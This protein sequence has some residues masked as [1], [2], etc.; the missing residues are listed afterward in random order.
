MHKQFGHPS[1]A[2]LIRLVENSKFKNPDVL[3]NIKE[4]SNK[5]IICMKRRNSKLKPVVCIPLATSFNEFVAVDLKFWEKYCFIVF[6]DIATRYCAAQ[7]ICDK[8][9]STI[10]SAFFNKWISIFGAPRKL[11]SDN[12]REF[13]NCELRSLAET[14][15]FLLYTTAAESPWSNGIVERLNGILGQSVGKIK[16]D[17]GCNVHI[18]LA[19]AVAARNA[20][21]NNGG[22]S[23]NTLVF[24]FNPAVPNVFNSGPSWQGELT[25][26]DIVRYNLQALHKA[27]QEYT[28]ASNNEKIR[29]ALKYKTRETTADEVSEGDLV[30]YKRQKDDLL[31]GPGTVA[32][33]CGKTVIVKHGGDSFRVHAVSIMKAPEK[34]MD[35]NDVVE[36][37]REASPEKVDST[38]TSHTHDSGS[39]KGQK[40]SRPDDTIDLPYSKIARSENMGTGEEARCIE[41]LRAGKEAK[42]DKDITDNEDGNNSIIKEADLAGDIIKNTKLDNSITCDPVQDALVDERVENKKTIPKTWKPKMRFHG[43]SK[44][45]GDYVSGEIVSRAGKVSGRNRSQYNVMLDQADENAGPLR[46]FDMNSL[47][48]LSILE[49]EACVLIMYSNDEVQQAKMK[50]IQAWEDNKVIKRVEDTG[51]ETISLRWVLTKKDDEVGGSVIKARLVARGYEEDKS[52]LR[53]DSPT[54]SKEGLRILVSIAS[55]F[56]WKC[57][58]IDVRAAYLQG[59]EINRELY[60]KPPKEF[61]VEGEVWRLLKTIYGL[62]DAARAWFLKVNSVLTNLGMLSSEL[63]NESLYYWAPQGKLQGLLA[64]HVDDF[65]YAG[66]DKFKFLVMNKFKTEFQIGSMAEKSFTY[67]GLR[68]CTFE[69][70]ITLDQVPY[71]ESLEYIPVDRA[72]I[73]MK[74][75]PLTSK[76]WTL[77]RAKVGQLNWLATHTRPDLAYEVSILGTYMANPKHRDIDRINKLINIAKKDPIQLYFPRLHKNGKWNMVCY[78]DAATPPKGAERYGQSDLD[79]QRSQGAHIIFLEDNDGK[80]TPIDWKSKKI[81]RVVSSALGAELLA[82]VDAIHNCRY[83]AGIV[84]TITGQKLGLITCFTD[85]KSLY[86]NLYSTHQLEDRQQRL[87][88]A[89]LKQNIK[90]EFLGGTPLCVKWVRCSLQ[91]ADVMTKRGVDTQNLRKVLDRV[92][93]RNRDI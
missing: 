33:K 17:V 29:R 71:T 62:V 39:V 58:A 47:D 16:E 2:K 8:K 14:F 66:N 35:M 79:S 43:Y 15:N 31:R 83:L 87:E 27:R 1:A 77:A 18:A 85:S 42:L 21:D 24:S 56:G 11:L 30:Y 72:K 80:R 82:M 34:V 93:V 59:D 49:A 76:E 88:M 40:R 65:L 78:V 86:D 12:G 4:I 3:K 7:V 44:D 92:L 9:P 37:P 73:K 6:V 74:D 46:W 48:E 36:M 13:N 91:L 63:L 90:G 84:S 51:Q 52:S 64:V 57:H 23:P 41:D 70:G 54:C 89:I 45:T 81:A 5:C 10:I 53:T 28:I 25:S 61:S 67:L 19:W 20:L 69:D 22:Y 75:R 32:G 26:L 55:S 50:E 60:V 68:L 38:D